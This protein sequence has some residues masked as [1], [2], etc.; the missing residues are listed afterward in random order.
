MTLDV[1]SAAQDRTPAPGAQAP[2]DL[3]VSVVI[4]TYNEEPNLADC[5]RSCA[6]CDDVH[7]VDSGSSDRTAEIARAMGAQ[8]HVH[9]FT[10]FGEQ[11]NWAI[12]HIGHRHDWVFHL[13]ADERFTP[14]LVAEMRRV[15]ARGPREAG[16]YVPHKMMFMGRWLRHAEGGYP[17]YQMRLFH[18]ER[19]RFRDYGH[20]QREHTSGKVGLLSKPYLHY[21]FSKGLEDWIDK[22][23]RYSTLEAREAFEAQRHARDAGDSPFG[24]AV[25]RRRF[26]KARIYPKL[27][28]KWLGRFVWMYVLRLGFLDGLA[29]LQYC[30]LV[31][32]YDLF[33]SLK[34]AELRRHAAGRRELTRTPELV[35]AA[36]KSIDDED[37]GQQR[38]AR[39]AAE[40]SRRVAEPAADASSNGNGHAATATPAGYVPLREESPWTM[41]E[42]IGRVLWMMAGATLFRPSFHN[43]Y[44]WRRMLLR[45]FGAR[46][47]R[48]VRVRPTARVEI[49]WNLEIGDGTAVGDHAI[50]YSL[51]RIRIGRHA[52]VSQYAHLCAGTH[53]YTDP[54]FPLLRPPIVVDD[55]A[56]IAAEAFIGPNVTVGPRA[57]VGA[58]AVV[59]KDVPADQ[60]VAGN[61]AKFIKART[62]KRVQ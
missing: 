29:G 30:L 35:T 33:T 36:V 38:H 47:G 46:I 56:W 58:R 24:N 2:G 1:A 25:E 41:R 54:A 28:G 5:L 55:E 13:D 6:W 17:I 16:F 19:M 34:L 23:N 20:G 32:T 53:D 3:P 59:V 61:P 39:A 42:K 15:L 18:R 8:L 37:R 4:L 12:D 51:G 43:W 48:D 44:G 40:A 57:I 49:P 26:F 22:H 10:S 11:R 45:C 9:P 52:T 21:N 7:V 60:I 27:P 50:L 62:L 14:E 31:S